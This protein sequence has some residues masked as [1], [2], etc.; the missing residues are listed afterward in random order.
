LEEKETIEV[1]Y[2]SSPDEMEF[3]LE[4]IYEIQRESWRADRDGG[5]LIELDAV[6][7]KFLNIYLKKAAATGNI[8]A[9]SLCINNE[10]AAF[11][12]TIIDRKKCCLLATSYKEKFNEYSPGFILHK[13]QV[14]KLFELGI[15]EYELGPSFWPGTPHMEWKKRWATGTK[16]NHWIWLYSNN[17]WYVSCYYYLRRL[18]GFV[19]NIMRFQEVKNK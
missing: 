5:V 13:Y 14:K 1:K 6:L 19:K 2:F 10:Y 12:L 4:K 9:T 11:I 3:A 16:E 17:H 15:K 7:K 18:S 8:L